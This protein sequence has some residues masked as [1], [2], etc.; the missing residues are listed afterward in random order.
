ME[1]LEFSDEVFRQVMPQKEPM[2]LCD[3][4]LANDLSLNHQV[5]VYTVGA[6]V[7]A[8]LTAKGELPAICLM[9][10]M[11]QTIA[12]I[13]SG[14][15]YEFDSDSVLKVGLFLSIRGF[16]MLKHFPQGF[17]PAGTKLYTTVDFFE[18]VE[19]VVLAEAIVSS[20]GEEIAKARLTVL[21]PTPQELEHAV[22]VEVAKILLSK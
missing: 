18:G 12:A 9:E 8:P 14:R 19:G 21:N 20:A 3:G 6:R 4:V 5:G 13:L 10:V 11:A 15:R 17:I 7:A 16:K 22:G 2:L 1:R